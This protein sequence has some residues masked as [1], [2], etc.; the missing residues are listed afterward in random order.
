VQR[1]VLRGNPNFVL[2]LMVAWNFL[3]TFLKGRNFQKEEKA[4]IWDSIEDVFNLFADLEKF[5]AKMQ[6][7]FGETI[8]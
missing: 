4:I 7:I 6:P 8:F 1:V 5:K 2:S 3:L